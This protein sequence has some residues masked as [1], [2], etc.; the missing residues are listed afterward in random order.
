MRRMIYALL[1]L[2]AAP[3]AMAQTASAYRPFVE[4]GK[5]W[6]VGQLTGEWDVAHILHYY[7]FEGDTLLG[8]ETYKRWMCRE[9]RKDGQEVT[10]VGALRE[11]DKKVFVVPAGQE[12]ADL[13]YDFGSPVGSPLRVYDFVLHEP[14]DCLLAEA[15]TLENQGRQLRTLKIQEDDPYGHLWVEGVGALNGPVCNVHL[16]VGYNRC[17]MRCS[18]GEEVLYEDPDVADGIASPA[19]QHAAFQGDYDLDGRPSRSSLRGIKV[20]RGR[21]VLNR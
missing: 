6:K 9:E 3:S 10:Y 17:L 12:S 2:L 7:Y 8:G 1:L 13:L 21:K 4:E 18:V 19:A 16:L 5:V 11:S 20:S 14:F 15:G